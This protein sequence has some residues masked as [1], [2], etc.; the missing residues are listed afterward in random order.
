[1]GLHV[2]IPAPVLS[3][4]SSEVGQQVDLFTYLAVREDSLTLYG[5]Q[6]RAERDLFEMLLGVS[7]IGPRTALATLSTLTPE[8]LANAVQ[9]DEPQIIARVPGLGKKTAQKL[10]LELKGKLLPTDMPEGIGAVSSS[11]AEVIEALTAL[12]Y[13]IVEAQAAVQAIPRD[14]SENIET[15]IMVALSYFSD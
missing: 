11:D 13:S 3:D 4:L 5:F 8:T 9:N 2:Y 6:T 1:V 12:G 10:I 15:R 7:G 14:T